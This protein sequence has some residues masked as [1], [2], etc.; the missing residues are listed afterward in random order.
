MLN[1]E[2]PHGLYP[3][4]VFPAVDSYADLATADLNHD[5]ALDIV[6][7]GGGTGG[8][9][10]AVS[11]GRGDGTFSPLTKY[12]VGSAPEALAIGDLNG[13]THPDVVVANYLSRS[14]SVL[15][16]AGDGTLRAHAAYATGGKPR[17]LA[18]ADLDRDGAADVVLASVEAS[19]GS[20]YR[21]SVFRGLGGGALGTPTDY[22]LL[23]SPTGLAAADVNG[24]LYP[25]IVLTQY[26]DYD[27]SALAVLLNRSDGTLDAAA[28]T[29]VP[30]WLSAVAVGDLDA[31]GDADLV[32]GNVKD[33]TL[34]VRLGLGD[35]TFPSHVSYRTGLNAAGG[36]HGQ[37]L[38]LADLN[39]DSRLDLVVATDQENAVAVFLG[40]GDGSLAPFVQY[41]QG[42][43][44]SAVA[45]G[46]FNGDGV[47]DIAR[48]HHDGVF[49]SV[50]F[51]RGDGSFIAT[52]AYPSGAG[53]GGI[54]SADLNGDRLADV[55]TLGGGIL[56]VLLR[57]ADGSLGPE[58]TY[59]V[60]RGNLQL[61]DL[62]GDGLPDIATQ[63]NLDVSVLLNLGDGTFAE[64]ADYTTTAE[65]APVLLAD[66][67][68]DGVPDMAAAHKYDAALELFLGRGDGTFASA[69][70]QPLMASRA[71]AAGDLNGD[72]HTDLLATEGGAW[73]CFWEAATA[74]SAAGLATW[75]GAP[76]SIWASATSTLTDGS[77]LWSSTTAGRLLVPIR[78]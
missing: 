67:N 22:A 58:T 32:L 6:T 46:D 54:V 63:W 13:D 65:C 41:P 51:G 69:A 17:S 26:L 21:L 2:S 3:D 42:Q 34:G 40:C 76:S 5:G 37:R 23:R 9:T 14:I 53:S 55:V 1:G 28:E 73:M 48:G 47:P 70:V 74:R 60:P 4:E 16:G 35:G 68:G 66:F 72:G 43:F 19:S 78:Y 11:L 45:V 18:I 27:N 39:A 57:R 59:A 36:L 30:G 77:T 71:I 38:V 24:D 33:Q 10:I 56:S 49:T 31:D 20:Y 8:S 12:P 25:D 50:L 61:A 29:I 15:L 7:A 64:R 62:N 52:P 75:A 44:T